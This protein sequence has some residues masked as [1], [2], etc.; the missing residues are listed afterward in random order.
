M[1]ISIMGFVV[2]ALLLTAGYYMRGPVIIAMIAAL[3]FGSTSLMTLTSLGGSSPLIYTM[4]AALFVG[5]M[6]IRRHLWS[7]LGTAFATIRVN[8]LIV[9]LVAYAIIGAWLFPRFFLGQTSVFVQSSSRYGVVEASLAPVNSNITQTAYFTLGAI[10]SIGLSVLLLARDRLEQVRRGFLVWASLHCAMGAIDL[11][12]KLAGAGDLLAPIRTANYVNLTEASEGGFWRIA[13]AFSEASSFGAV[14]LACIAFSYTYWRKSG[15]RYARNLTF[16]LLVL[17]LLSTSSTAYVGIAIISLPVLVGLGQSLVAK[18]FSQ[19]DVLIVV[20]FTTGAL[21]M[22]ALVL[23]DRA[24][25]EPF[26][27]LVDDMVFNK[28][29]SDSGQERTYWNMKSL[30][31]FADTGGLGIGFGSSRAS[32][33]PIAVISQLGAIGA[34]M[35]A[36]LALVIFRGLGK[37][38]GA[39]DRQTEATVSAVR[40]ASLAG[41]VAGS[42]ISGTADPGML[43]FIALAVIASTRARVRL[44]SG[45]AAAAP[46]PTP[47]NRLA[48]QYGAA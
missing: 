4:F 18:R 40:A 10:T 2:C 26:V 12:G 13:G 27:R 29:S 7:E 32:S 41:M 37:M 31:A 39:V 34:L 35:T 8:W 19:D 9:G 43:F 36:A 45:Y 47:P 24:F 1:Q 46:A 33:W 16:A 23:S 3:A 15:S 20:T 21:L 48:T 11:V 22:L 17:L 6:V 42:L 28:L 25:F 44:R 30:Q 38:R 5:T 14:S